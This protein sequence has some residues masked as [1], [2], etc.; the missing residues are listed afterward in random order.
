MATRFRPVRG[1]EDEIK[2][3]EQHDGYIYI[4]TDTGKMYL[5][6][7]ER[8]ITIASGGAGGGNSSILYAKAENVNEYEDGYYHI[9][10]TDLEDSTLT[11]VPVDTVIINQDGAFYRVMKYENDTIYCIRIAVSGGGDNTTTGKKISVDL[12]KKINTSS[13]INGKSAYAIITPH[14]GTNSEGA[15]LDGYLTVTWK[16]ATKNAGGEYVTYATDVIDLS[17]GESYE[18]DFG[19]R[20]KESSTSYLFVEASGIKSGVS[21]SMY[22]PF[23]TMDLTLEK[24]S[25]FTNTSVYSYDNVVASVN[26]TGNME[27]IVDYYF[28]GELI[29]SDTLAAS[30][31]TAQ[32]CKFNTYI[33]EITHGYHTVRVELYQSIQGARGVGTEPIEMEIAV[34]AKGEDPIIWL[35]D[36]ATRYYAYDDISIPYFVFDP[37]NLSGFTV[38]LLKDNIKIGTREFTDLKSGLAS[39]NF[40]IT[41]AEEGIQNYYSITCGDS[42][43]DIYFDVVKDPDRDMTLQKSLYLA[44]SFDA[45]GRSND[46]S[47]TS[48][49]TLSLGGVNCSF[50]DFNWYNNGW[51]KGTDGNTCLRISNGASFSVP[52]GAMTFADST[53]QNNQSHSFEFQFRIRNVQNYDNL[54]KN[55]TRYKNDSAYYEAFYGFISYAE[56]TANVYDINA[57]YFIKDDNG[58]YVDAGI[59][60]ANSYATV[61]ANNTVYIGTQGYKT[62]YTNYDAFLKYY[63]EQNNLDIDAITAEYDYTEK[64]FDLSAITCGFYSGKAAAPVG[65]GL[66]PQDA[67]FTN[68]TNT[69]NAS[70]VEDKLVNLSITYDHSNKLMAIYVNGILTGV[71]YSTLDDPFTINS[72]NIVFS[73]NVCDIDLYKFRVYTTALSLN[74]VVTNYAVDLKNVTIYDQNA[75]A[76]EN[77]AINEYQFDYKKMLEYNTKHPSDPIMPYIIFDTSE[78]DNEDRL[79]WSKSTKLNIKVEFVNTVLERAYESGEL[80][81]LADKAGTTVEDYYLHHCPSF[82]SDK[83]QMAVQGTSSEFYPRRNY[84]LKMKDSDK[85][86]HM[87]ANRGPFAVENKDMS[88]FYMDNNTVGT[89]KFTMKIDYMESSGSYNRG[90]GNLLKNAYSKHPLDYYLAAGALGVEKVTASETPATEYEK[91]NKKLYFYKNH[92]GNWKCTDG[93]EDDI[94][95]L[96]ADT[97][98]QGPVA[99]YQDL[100]ATDPSLYDKLKVLTDESSPY[101]NKWFVGSKSLEAV[102]SAVFSELRTTVQGYP[103]LAFHKKSDGTYTYIGRYNM[104][105]DKGSDE[106]YGFKGQDY[107]NICDDNNTALEDI[108]E[109]WEFEN[110]QRG[111]CSF[112]DPKNRKTLSFN[113]EEWDE[114]FRPTLLQDFE[115]R[116]NA[117]DGTLDAI[118][119]V[120]TTNATSLDNLSQSQ[121]DQV[122]KDT[123]AVVD[124]ADVNTSR[125]VIFDMYGNYEK[126]CQWVWSTCLD[127]SFVKKQAEIDAMSEDEK[128]DYLIREYTKVSDSDSL[129]SSKTYYQYKLHL[130]KEYTPTEAT[131]ADDVAA[132]LYTSEIKTVTYGSTTYTYDSYEYRYQKFKNELTNHFNLDYVATYFVVTEVLELYDSRGKNCMMASW[133]PMKKGGDYIWFP[134]F[135]D[136]DTQL[137][138]NNTGIPSFEY[139]IDATDEGSFS[140]NDSVLWNNF[141][142]CFKDAVTQKYIQLKGQTEGLGDFEALSYAPFASVARIEGWYESDPNICKNHIVMRGVRPLSAI[143]LD[144]Y[145]KYISITNGKGPGYQGQTGGY[146]YDNTDTTNGTGQP[147]GSYFYALQGDRSLSRQQFLT[148]RLNYLE[149]WLGVGSYQKSGSSDTAF[150]GRI[151]FNNLD[152]STSDIWVEDESYKPGAAN[153]VKGQAEYAKYWADDAQTQ[154]TNEFDGEYWM[155]VTPSRKSYVRLIADDVISSAKY[156]ETPVEVELQSLK[157]AAMSSPKYKEQLLYVL[158]VDIIQNLGNLHK[159]YFTELH[160]INAPNLTTLILGWDGLDDNGNAYKNHKTN[161][162]AFS[163]MPLLQ[164]LNLSNISYKEDVDKTLDLSGSEKLQN[165]RAVGSNFTQIKFASGVALNTLYLPSTITELKL[166]EARQLKNIIA[167]HTTPTHDKK[168]DTLTAEPGLYIE[169]FTDYLPGNPNGKSLSDADCIC[170]INT[171]SIIDAANMGYDA[172]KLLLGYY[173]KRNADKNASS[174]AMTELDATPYKKVDN[175]SIY[176]SNRKYYVDNYHLGLEEYTYDASTW[177]NAIKNGILFVLDESVTNTVKDVAMFEDLAVNSLFTDTSSGAIPNITGTIYIDNSVT[178]KTSTSGSIVSST[179]G[180]TYKW[181]V[182]DTIDEEYV[183]NVLGTQYPNLTFFFKTITK[184]YTARFILLDEDNPNLYTTIGIQTIGAGSW[185]KN[186]VDAYGDISESKANYDFYGWATESDATEDKVLVN[187]DKS[188][189][190]WDNQSLSAETTYV[191]YA[192]F[193]I[194]K[195]EITFVNGDGTT[196]LSKIPYGEVLTD[197]R[198]VLPVNQTELM[199]TYKDDSE[200]GSLETYVFNGWATTDGGDVIKLSNY[201]S[202][203]DRTFY[204]TFKVGNVHD[205]ATNESYFNI[206]ELS[207]TATPNTSLKGKVTIPTTINGI[208]VKAIGGFGSTWIREGQE[209]W[210]QGKG[211]N[212]TGIY[213]MP[214]SKVETVVSK[215]FTACGRLSYFEWPATLTVIE[216]QA[217]YQC[218]NLKSIDLSTMSKFER[219]RSGSF[220]NAW[221][222]WENTVDLVL[223]GNTIAIYNGAFSYANKSA[224]SYRRRW[225]NHQLKQAYIKEHGSSDGYE[226]LTNSDMPLGLN[227]VTIGGPEQPAQ[228]STLENSGYTYARSYTEGQVYYT[229]NSSGEYDRVGTISS[230]EEFNNNIALQ[231]FY[232]IN[233]T[234]ANYE[235]ATTWEANR[236]Y[237]TQ[238]F[239][240]VGILTNSAF[241]SGTYYVIDETTAN[242]ERATTWNSTQ[243]YYLMDSSGSYDRVSTGVLTAD[244]FWRYYTMINDPFMNTSI[245]NVYYDNTVVGEEDR[246][247]ELFKAYALNTYPAY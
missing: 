31:D 78:A 35:G 88:W 42:R 202:S 214:D 112:R 247:K 83:A 244:Q 138:I 18:F 51:V 20:A 213:F 55:I 76:V 225:Y 74:D 122:K 40:E 36:Y 168:T 82:T 52:I 46:E 107:L 72:S 49:S 128:K 38:E 191:F 143:N 121:I 8:R 17:D 5:D 56:D 84:K 192:I 71:I 188:I 234:T 190:T 96:T 228:I 216:G 45:K 227:S 141:Y 67:F 44:M 171:L 245:V 79:S 179:N 1:T 194:H 47:A 57:Y 11:D 211:E 236:V 187:A 113:T 54:I 198:E 235:L 195:Y 156:T 68:G 93:E 237:Y 223:P 73:S 43:R 9:S 246:I 27:K 92:K 175:G 127:A 218:Y 64:R 116:Y 167:T 153:Y 99:V 126:V 173:Q 3:F 229:K 169:H 148:N 142:T 58:D 41:D 16:L 59:T 66:G 217:F 108:A 4:A 97:F 81:D 183:R 219:F 157:T 180:K 145:Y 85:V 75:I 231:E 135:Y 12:D 14:S 199:A 220:Q 242:Y 63:A 118:A 181:S 222:T 89:T 185:F 86:V 119:E 161:R 172:Y 158:G 150:W 162:Y 159:L 165:F 193:S 134:I 136:M 238:E 91:K 123:G 144:E 152:G 154:K 232:V 25:S 13:Y 61:K 176:N 110:N 205:Q 111:F 10:V 186:P 243:G 28:D 137:G 114:K 62:K 164:E 129:D 102:D 226:E 130:Y 239:K 210:P 147:L 15:S 104:L 184:S 94:P 139:Y 115:Y 203:K 209:G 39:S 98:A 132:G 60:D 117:K 101:Y 109:C 19:S 133:G 182:G 69:V 233:E 65:F 29:H 33:S 189:N 21:E 37:N 196:Y 221:Y 163:S 215:A 22:F 30:S 26:I 207:G 160:T 50:N 149:S 2:A 95:A 105:L 87:T 206:D 166:T 53:N 90:L 224:D 23:T 201:R 32:S 140:T 151:A 241:A 7:K 155:T 174:V 212:V 120:N 230:S 6:T 204:S 24:S 70:Y 77:N 34:N 200:L 48:R 103:V 197:P 125:E 100:M 208:T 131:W 124:N 146:L 106:M 170:G 240:R 178:L 177:D 80:E